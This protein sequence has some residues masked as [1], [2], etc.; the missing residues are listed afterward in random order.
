MSNSPIVPEGSLKTTGVDAIDIIAVIKAQETHQ[1][2]ATEPPESDK[3]SSKEP[4][5]PKIRIV[6]LEAADFPR[7]EKLYNVKS[8]QHITTQPNVPQPNIHVIISTGSGIGLAQDFYTNALSIVL[9]HLSLSPEI[10]YT[11]HTTTSPTSITSLIH[12]VIAPRANKGVKQR[13]ILLS[14]DGGVVDIVNALFATERSP[15]FT[16]PELSLLPLGTGNALAHSS[17]LTA[18]R[19]TGLSA[20]A[21]GSPKPVPVFRATFSPGS[22]LLVDEGRDEVELEQRDG[23]GNPI[24]R[25]AVVASWGLHA[26]LVADSDTAEYRKFGVE[27]FGMAAKEA[28]HPADGSLPHA[29]AGRVSVLREGVDEKWEVLNREK[30]AYIL[31]T[32]V[33]ELEKGF[34][35]SPETKPL[36]GKMRLVHFGPMEGEEVMR[37]LMLA[38]Q[39]GKHVHEKEIGYEP[40]E[41]IRIEFHED[42]WRWRRVCVDGMIIKVEEG[43]WVEVRMEKE[44]VIDLI[45]LGE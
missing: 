21:L 6:P 13:I 3:P 39:D 10:D 12:S 16:S 28:L 17:R 38:Y 7:V 44:T 37:I 43:G 14:G 2:I 24:I 5:I 4:S 41:G 30:H 31:A 25:G 29:Y 1:I 36:D 15:A 8:L 27:R 34:S 40:I 33:K 22:R 32:L 45:T 35:I 20:L 9:A 11:I 23:D 42:E 26:S 19:T 18:D